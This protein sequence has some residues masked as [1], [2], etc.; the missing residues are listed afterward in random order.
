[1]QSVSV[2][3]L[4]N[5]SALVLFHKL[6]PKERS[7]TY[8]HSV[9]LFFALLVA[10]SFASQQQAFSEAWFDTSAFARQ[11]FGAFGTA[12]RNIIFADGARNLDLAV[13]K[14]TQFGKEHNGKA[15]EFRAEF[16]NL[17][18]HP[19]F[20][21]PDLDFSSTTFGQIFSTARGSTERVIQFGLKLGF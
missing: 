20:G 19:Q 5:G 9:S 14:R 16:F 10:Q 21:P 12:G 17:L 1:L 7:C 13:I 4:Q 3:P 18:N 11:S 6:T 8:P 2:S 15:V